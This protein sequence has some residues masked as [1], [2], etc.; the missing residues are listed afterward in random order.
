MLIVHIE[1]GLEVLDKSRDTQAFI[2][3]N[4]PI[5]KYTK[6]HIEFDDKSREMII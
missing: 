3:G 4:Q 1:V 6:V 2:H 5:I